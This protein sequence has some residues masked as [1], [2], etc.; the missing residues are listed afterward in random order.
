[1]NGHELH[2]E[3][4]RDMREPHRDGGGTLRQDISNAMVGL[5]KEHLGKGP[6]RCRAYLEPDLVLVVLGG[7]A[8][9][10]ASRRC[11][12]LAG[13]MRSARRDRSGRTAC[14]SGSWP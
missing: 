10:Q 2:P 8:I 9:R 1:M 12:R 14:R 13:G 3:D 4:A 11:S 6:V 7:G 5:Y